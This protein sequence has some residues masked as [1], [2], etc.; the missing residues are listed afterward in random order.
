MSASFAIVV[1][2]DEQR[3]IGRSGAL[4]WRIARDM[5]FFRELTS[6][7]PLGKQNAVMMGRKTY[8]SLPA[9][10]RPLPHRLNVVLSRDP[11][12]EPSGAIKADSLDRAMKE[13][14]G[15]EDIHDRF[16]IGG[17]S[18]YAAALDD[19]RCT[20]VFITRVHAR[21]ECDTY[22]APFE[23]DFELVTKDGPYHEGNL[24]FTFETYRR[25]R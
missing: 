1:A 20:R 12:Y 16:V 7:A 10:F 24:A 15:R 8:A 13:L 6:K 22:L 11:S 19:A 21:L 3:G 2:A 5:A 14:A 23:H 25:S 9:R 17:G 4:P 18:L